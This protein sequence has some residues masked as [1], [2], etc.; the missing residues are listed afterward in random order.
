M[1]TRPGGLTAICVIV[2]VL[3]GLG[4]LGGLLGAVGQ[5]ASQQMQSAFSGMNQPGMDNDLAEMQMEMNKQM[6]GVQKKWMP[7]TLSFLAASVLVS[8]GLLLGAI[9]SLQAKPV[10]RTILSWSL[11]LAILVDGGEL[12][13]TIMAQMETVDVMKASMGKMMQSQGGNAPPGSAEMMSG[14]MSIGAYVG[15]AFVVI[16]AVLLIGFYLFSLVYL[17]KPHVAAYFADEDEGLFRAEIVGP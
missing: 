13:P 16:W 15:I 3:A 4:I 7:I 1:K 5:L 8:V 14:F 6:M 10:G 12:I 17:G 9:F 2:L 11:V